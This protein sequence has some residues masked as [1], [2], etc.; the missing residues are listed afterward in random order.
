MTDRVNEIGFYQDLA[1][2]M[3][4]HPDWYET[5]GEVDFTLG[6]VMAD[7]SGS[8][9][10]VLLHFEELGCAEVSPLPEGGEASCDCWLEGDTASWAEMFDDI[11]S[12]GR[13]TGKRTINSL[14]LVGDHIDVRG[15][16]PMGVDKFFRFNQ[17]IQQFLDGAAQLAPASA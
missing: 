6:V 11:A 5:L 9:L 16:D 3:N 8:D 13:A 14:T 1:D 10:R 17:T 7:E 4:A 2:L 15:G 12:N